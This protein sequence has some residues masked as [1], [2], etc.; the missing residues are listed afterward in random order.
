M[1]PRTKDILDDI[2]KMRA[3]GDTDTLEHMR[4]YWDGMSDCVELV[5]QVVSR[6]KTDMIEPVKEAFQKKEN[7]HPEQTS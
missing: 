1:D 3:D 4:D 5:M 6:L 2:E 7:S